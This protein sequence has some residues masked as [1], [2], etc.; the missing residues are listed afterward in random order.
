MA[1]RSGPVAWSGQRK[2][3]NLGNVGRK[4]NPVL[5]GT[6]GPAPSYIDCAFLC[7]STPPWCDGSTGKLPFRA[8][9]GSE[10]ASSFDESNIG[11]TANRFQT[12]RHRSEERRVGKEGR[13]R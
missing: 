6:A 8:E 4:A 2:N 3:S 13:S 11:R 10:P 12:R 9:C 1:A 7:P 5:K